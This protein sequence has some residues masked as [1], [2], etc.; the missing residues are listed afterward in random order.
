MNKRNGA[1][2]ISVFCLL[3]LQ[4]YRRSCSFFWNYVIFEKVLSFLIKSVVDDGFFVLCN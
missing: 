2:K 1:K 3:M 4:K